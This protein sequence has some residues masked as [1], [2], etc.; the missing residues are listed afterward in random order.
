MEKNSFYPQT[1]PSR[2]I[3]TRNHRGD[4]RQLLQESSAFVATPPSPSV[5]VI[6]HDREFVYYIP[7]TDSES[8]HYEKCRSGLGLL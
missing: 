2:A 8:A 5:D 3:L 4:N 1:I 6:S 7:Q